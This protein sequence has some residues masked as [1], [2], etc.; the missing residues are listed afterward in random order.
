MCPVLIYRSS[1][2][3][4]HVLHDFHPDGEIVAIYKNARPRAALNICALPDLV[5]LV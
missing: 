1:R 5:T 4:S 3:A 2:Q